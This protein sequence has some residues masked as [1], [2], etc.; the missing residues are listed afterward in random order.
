MIFW[1]FTQPLLLESTL[2]F[3]LITR[4]GLKTLDI[5]LSGFR[6]GL[7]GGN[8]ICFHLPEDLFLL[9]Q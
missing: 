9:K 1:D 2:E 5:L 7:Q 4:Q 8:Q 3:R 6:V